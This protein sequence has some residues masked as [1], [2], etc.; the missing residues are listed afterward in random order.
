MNIRKQLQIIEN[1]IMEKQAKAPRAIQVEILPADDPRG[2]FPPELAR[3][4]IDRIR[5]SKEKQAG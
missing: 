5:A 3:F 2:G 1:S 4:F